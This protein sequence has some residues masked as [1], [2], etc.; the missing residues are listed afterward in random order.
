MEAISFSL[1]ALH[2]AFATT[3]FIVEVISTMKSQNQDFDELKILFER[4]QLY[5]KSFVKWFVTDS[6]TS[7]AALLF[8]IDD[9][10]RTNV[11][12]IFLEL[13]KL[14]S[15][16]LRLAVKYDKKYQQAI[17][18][19]E[20]GDW[21]EA[22]A[23][24]GSAET[25]GL[26]GVRF[27]SR[28]GTHVN[29]MEIFS[30]TFGVNH[31]LKEDQPFGLREKWARKR[32]MLQWGLFDHRRLTELVKKQEQWTQRLIE[33]MQ[34]AL[35]HTISEDKT[36]LQN[37]TTGEEKDLGFSTLPQAP[38]IFGAEVQDDAH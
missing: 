26:V 15:E 21:T 3:S 10:W 19:I 31:A 28:D 27:L 16:Y 38:T 34:F 5:L 1:S 7:G 8:K 37:L 13:R 18:K 29:L 2:A 32:L 9:G 25:G 17:E 4:H 30:R 20:E 12:K 35:M 23:N 33:L 22:R 24:D 6:N 14:I 11:M 36:A